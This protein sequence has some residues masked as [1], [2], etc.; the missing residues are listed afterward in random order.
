MSHFMK[1]HPAA[2]AIPEMLPAEFAALKADIESRGLI[3]PI[4]TYKGQLLDGRHR[5][6]EKDYD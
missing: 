4:E 5:F 1:I 3:V 2:K 6:K